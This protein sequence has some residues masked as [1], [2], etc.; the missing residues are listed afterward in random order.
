M[1]DALLREPG[2]E[3]VLD[4]RSPAIGFLALHGG[5]LDRLTDV[6]AGEAA[7]RSGA[8]LYAIVQPPTLRW[9]IPSEQHDPSLAPRLEAFLDHVD[10]VISVHG[11]GSDGASVRRGSSARARPPDLRRCV[12][13]QAFV[14]G[15]HNRAL[16][17]R[18]AT[19]L[20]RGV[21]DHPVVVDPDEVPRRLAAR[22][23]RNPVNGTRDGGMQVEVPAG[24][25]GLLPGWTPRLTELS[26]A[27]ATVAA[28][29]VGGP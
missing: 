4:L 16:A 3:E 21:P 14:L 10:L 25:R 20:R 2:V 6:I 23:P 17:A 24:A 12:E 15:G 11:Y 5:S 8:S 9:H 29:L 18:V 27:L 28:E 26:T 13:L 1:L 19:A 7:A 22:H